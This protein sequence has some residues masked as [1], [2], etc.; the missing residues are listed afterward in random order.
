MLKVIVILRTQIIPKNINPTLF[1]SLIKTEVRN[2]ATPDKI[3]ATT[4]Q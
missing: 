1:L 3:G 2:I 4:A